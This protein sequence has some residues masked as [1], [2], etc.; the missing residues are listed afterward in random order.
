MPVDMHTHSEFSH[1]SQCPIEDMWAKQ[2]ENGTLPFAV[3]DH[4]ETL[5]YKQ[6]D[7]FTPIAQAAKKVEDL[8]AAHADNNILMGVE[9][10][11]GFLYPEVTK[12][13]L[14][15]CEYDVVLGSA[16]FIKTDG[17]DESFADVDFSKVDIDTIKRYLDDYFADLLKNIDTVDIDI[18]TH[19][20]YPFRY[21]VE[22]YK[23]EVDVFDWMP[24]MK[25]I[26]ARIIEK[27]VALEVNTAYTNGKTTVPPPEILQIYYDMGGR[28]ITLGSDAHVAAN[29]SAWFKEAVAILKEIGFTE[30]YYYR[31]RKPYPLTI[32]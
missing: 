20:T 5:K 8:N 26:L 21:V 22:K 10:G 31:K 27:G 1:D 15:L 17:L 24:Q 13:V 3:T 2:R 7:I 16:H 30:T 12:K 9:I 19:L 4:C 28:L 32:E 6:I 14:E 25:E 23:R 11:D 29:A 18:L